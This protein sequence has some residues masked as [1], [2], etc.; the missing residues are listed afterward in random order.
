MSDLILS[1]AHPRIVLSKALTS[2]YMETRL[3]ATHHLGRLLHENP[4]LTDWALGLMI[5]QLYDTAM[6]VCEVAVMYLEEACSEGGHLEKV[7]ELR[8]ALEHLG[9]VGHPLF[10]RYAGTVLPARQ[11]DD[12][13][14]S[15]SIGFMYL[16]H[17]QYI[18]RELDDWLQ[19]RRLHYDL[20]I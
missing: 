13:F 11:A 12:S 7:V 2:A 15:T 1:D 14:V 10:M 19:V 3:F 5:T 4:N 6:E 8:P 9:E 17:A 18:E 20:W 16:H